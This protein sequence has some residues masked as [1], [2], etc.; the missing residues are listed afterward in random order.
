MTSQEKKNLIEK[1]LSEDDKRSYNE[2]AADLELELWNQRF[3]SNATKLRRSK[4]KSSLNTE[5]GKQQ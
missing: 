1:R 5:K 2:I 4:A 3:S